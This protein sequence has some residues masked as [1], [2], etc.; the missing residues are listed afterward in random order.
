M[1]SATEYQSASVRNTIIKRSIS[2]GQWG[3]S[4]TYLKV[5]VL[6]WSVVAVLHS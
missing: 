1:N 4:F 5:L 6:S 3:W 2:Y